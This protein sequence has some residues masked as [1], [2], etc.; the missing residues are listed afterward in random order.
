MTTFAWVPNFQDC[1][2]CF[3]ASNSPSNIIRDRDACRVLGGNLLRPIALP[4]VVGL[5]SLLSDQTKNQSD[6]KHHQTIF[7]CLNVS[8]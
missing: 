8:V 4:Q 2:L 7:D 6:S 5:A 1:N 3:D